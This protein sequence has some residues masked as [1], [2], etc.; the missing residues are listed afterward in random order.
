MAWGHAGFPGQAATG[1]PI[2]LGFS[3]DRRPRSADSGSLGDGTWPTRVVR[4][5][6]ILHEEAA[7]VKSKY[8]ENVVEEVAKVTIPPS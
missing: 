1:P 8:M 2:R 5:N 6:A 7:T 4:I 3:S